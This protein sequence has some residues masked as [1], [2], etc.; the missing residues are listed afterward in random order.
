MS[1]P[2]DKAHRILDL[3]S[4]KKIGEVLSY[5]EYVKIKEE[6]E[7]TEEILDDENLYKLI[8][9]G[10]GELRAGEIV[11]LEDLKHV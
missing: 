2:R 7:A 10:L 11:G 8:K 5:L 4:E 6:L 1:V 3:I 9:K